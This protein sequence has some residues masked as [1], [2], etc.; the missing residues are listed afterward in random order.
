MYLTGINCIKYEI[1]FFV[2]TCAQTISRKRR[3]VEDENV[4]ITSFPRDSCESCDEIRRS[5]QKRQA[6][7][8]AETEEEIL[9]RSYGSQLRCV[10]VDSFNIM[11]PHTLHRY[12]CGLARRFYDTEAEQH[13][14][15]RWMTCNWNTTWTRHD[16]LDECVWVQ[17][18]NPPHVRLVIV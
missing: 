6:K 17:C 8:E 4:S 16:S 18:L 12:E 3:D 13:Y 5:V 1:F 9:L 11:I 15:E 7:A 14:D 2:G 10:M